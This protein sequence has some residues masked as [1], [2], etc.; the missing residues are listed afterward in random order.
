M[1]SDTPPIV[2]RATWLEARRELLD[3]EKALTRQR[4]ELAARRRRQ[5]W[6]RVETDY[7]FDTPEGPRRLADL[8][9]GRPQL[10][11][12]HFML[13]PDWQEGCPSCSFWADGYDGLTAHLAA[14][15][16]TLVA[17]SR[18]PVAAI[19]AYRERMGWSFTWVSSLDNEFNM[20][21][22]V[23]FPEG[24][25]DDRTYNFVPIADPP[26]ELPGL[27]VFFRD[28]VGGIFH[29]YSCYARGLDPFNA[30]YQI[31]DLT[32][33]GRHEDDLEWSMAWLRRHDQ[34]DS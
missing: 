3:A 16:T 14:R 34:Y 25:R 24:H 9:E 33:M 22:G 30:A 18:A 4:D 31:L 12:Y 21:L 13:G 19:E 6:V 2:D 32:P 27:S 29:T 11:V 17:V 23:S 5:P 26:E 1:T 10:V 15:D 28:D 7:T 20:D 8:F